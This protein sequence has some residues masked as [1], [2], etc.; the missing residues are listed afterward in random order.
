MTKKSY[1]I[2]TLVFYYLFTQKIMVTVMQ[3]LFVGIALISVVI[4]YYLYYKGCLKKK[5]TNPFPWVIWTLA[6]LDVWMNSMLSVHTTDL[7]VFANSIYFFGPGLISL[8]LI[9]KNG[10][11]H[12]SN[13]EKIFAGIALI[14]L[15]L[16]MGVRYTGLISAELHD[17]VLTSMVVILELGIFSQLFLEIKENPRLES[18]SPWITWSI[19]GVFALLAIENHSY[20][21]SA[22]IVVYLVITSLLSVYLWKKQYKS[23]KLDSIAA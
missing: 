19:S 20:A 22:V 21:G 13:E 18:I 10:F 2:V 8:T 11:K 9:R 23:G 15:I 17:Y 3:H 5:E 14:G 12:I 4:A 1:K 16:V 6:G 7:E